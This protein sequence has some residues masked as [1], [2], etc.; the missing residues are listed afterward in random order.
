MTGIAATWFVPG[1]ETPLKE[2]V[3]WH[4]ADNILDGVMLT[5]PDGRILAANPA[6][7]AMLGL[8]EEEIVRRGRAGIVAPD[9]P[10]VEA[11]LAERQRTGAVS[12]DLRFVRGDGTTIL[13]DATS[14]VFAGPDR[15]LLTALTF[16]DV[17]ERRALERSLAESEARFRS[18]ADASFE[19]VAVHVGGR[20]VDANDHFFRLFGHGR[21]VL[22]RMDVE[23]LVAPASLEL[24]RDFVRRRG[25]GPL[26]IQLRRADGST[27]WAEVRAR[28]VRFNGSPARV[29]AMRDVDERRRAEADR[30]AQSLVAL[31]G[32]IAHELNNAVQAMLTAT[33]LAETRL[34]DGAEVSDLF[35][36]LRDSLSRV[37]GLSRAMLAYSGRQHVVRRDVNLATLARAAVQGFRESMPAARVEDVEVAARPTV[38]VDEPALLSVV[39]ELLENA[40]EATHASSARIRVRVDVD[41][42]QAVVEVIDRGGGMDAETRARMFEPFF[43][44]RFPGRGL[45]LAASLGIVRAHGGSIAVDSEP[46]RG[47]RVRVCLPAAPAV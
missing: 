47:T 21:D 30:S 26:D 19:A 7:C 39:T 16:R 6:A 10:N 15:T 41:G 25:A 13:V 40:V 45:G 8:D 29:A 22:G 28:D 35:G 42:D 38:R 17:T 11:A 34:R 5:A 3:G 33:E 31:A 43:S 9:D 36:H 46:G 1:V 18:L 20:L 2:A 14:R 32:G 12:T 27:F 44:T 24:A 37:A 4:L 23:E